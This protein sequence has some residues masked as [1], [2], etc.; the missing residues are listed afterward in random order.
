MKVQK[1]ACGP[2][3]VNAYVVADQNKV[4]AVI[5]PADAEPILRYLQQEGLDCQQILLTH[6]HFD[7]I[8][9]V[10]ELKERTNAQVLIHEQDANMLTSDQDN[11]AAFSGVHVPPCKADVHLQDGA[12][13]YIGNLHAR[14]L[15]TPGHSMGSVCYLFEAQRVL[16][17]GDTLFRLSVGRSDFVHSDTKLLHQ[18]IQDRL[19]TLQGDYVI[20]PG[21]MRE[22]TLDF[23]RAH[24]PFLRGEAKW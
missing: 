2:L 7:H 8:G 22:S 9:G 3:N 5:D 14:V 23:E 4:C 20:Y 6:G 1:I 18:S 16:F 17:T 19:M 15:H 21:H 24:N 13:I 10:A 11:L 12:Q